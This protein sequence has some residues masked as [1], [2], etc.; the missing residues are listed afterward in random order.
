L[1]GATTSVANAHWH[2]RRDGSRQPP[3]AAAARITGSRWRARSSPFGFNDAFAYAN[4][5]SKW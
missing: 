4:V 2:R 5:H 3:R 1:D